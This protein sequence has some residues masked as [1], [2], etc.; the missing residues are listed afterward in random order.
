MIMF[1]ASKAGSETLIRS[2]QLKLA[3]YDI[4]LEYYGVNVDLSFK[5]QII[6]LQNNTQVTDLQCHITDLRDWFNENQA[7]RVDE[8]PENPVYQL[9]TT[10]ENGYAY[11]TG[12]FSIRSRSLVVSLDCEGPGGSE[13]HV[14]FPLAKV[15]TCRVEV[16]FYGKS[17]YFC[18]ISLCQI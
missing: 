17:L 2:F 8:P 15:D 14:T 9:G 7:V 4:R 6:V 18:P 13:Y 12:L 3:E 5:K 11:L 10:N 1:A 16:G